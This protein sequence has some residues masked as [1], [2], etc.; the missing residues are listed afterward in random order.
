MSTTVW[1]VETQ[2]CKLRGT[3]VWYIRHLHKL[4][5]ARVLCFILMTYVERKVSKRVLS[6]ICRW[7]VFFFKSNGT[8]FRE[9][10]FVVLLTINSWFGYDYALDNLELTWFQGGQKRKTAKTLFVRSALAITTDCGQ[11]FLQFVVFRK[12]LAEN[13][14]DKLYCTGLMYP[15]NTN[16]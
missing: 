2:L 14:L 15:G 4:S 7:S 10:L 5:F 12:L 16:G 6:S 3:S 13:W 8:L 9:V 11:L 1:M